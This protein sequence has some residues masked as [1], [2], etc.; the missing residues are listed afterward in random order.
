[1]PVV[2]ASRGIGSP[3]PREGAHGEVLW[4]SFDHHS[5]NAESAFI[6]LGSPDVLFH[7]AWSGLSNFN[8][9]QHFESELPTQYR[10]LRA[11]IRSGL[12]RV[13]IAGTCLEYG[14]QSGALSVDTPTA[15]TTAYGFAKD[16]LRRQLEFL[17]LHDDYELIW[18]RLFYMY[19]DGQS[20]NSLYSMLR[21]AVARGDLTFPMSAGE[22][23]RDYLPIGTIARQ[24]VDLAYEDS[25]RRL[26]NICSGRPMSVRSLVER[27]VSENSWNI[28]LDLGR[29]PYPDYEPL[30]FWGVPV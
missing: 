4:V 7:L 23:L 9:P 30:A 18:A 21:A 26:L 14:M 3:R 17:R 15:P 8:D 13:V 29:Y 27:W 1:M 12:R 19:G 5:D 2:A 25:P 22:Q 24:L 20:E 28:E 11:L 16:T 6:R 10:F